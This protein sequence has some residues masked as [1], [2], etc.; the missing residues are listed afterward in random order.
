M[1]RHA[2][3]FT[4][5]RMIFFPI[6]YFPWRNTKCWSCTVFLLICFSLVIFTLTEE[7]AE[8]DP[9]MTGWRLN[10]VYLCHPCVY[11]GVSV[12]YLKQYVTLGFILWL[13]KLETIFSWDNNSH[14]NSWVKPRITLKEKSQMKEG[15]TSLICI[16][17]QGFVYQPHFRE[18]WEHFIQNRIH[19]YN[20]REYGK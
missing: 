11:E 20:S 2:T 5:S 3:N 10:T 7:I 1:Y 6:K 4:S 12:F 14:N 13:S 15:W 19:N 17:L 9:E 8:S 18:K 16:L